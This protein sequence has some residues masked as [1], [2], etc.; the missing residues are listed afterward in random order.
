[1]KSR[2]RGLFIILA[3]CA[4]SASQAATF[5]TQLSGPAEAPPNASPGTGNATVNFDLTAHLLSIDMSFS[6]LTSG[7]TAS[8]IHCCTAPPAAAPVAT[9][10]PTFTGFPLGVTSGTYSRAFNTL[11]PATWNPTFVTANGG[12][13]AGAEAAL[14]A[15]LAAGSSYLNVHTT[16]FPAGEIRG[17]LTAAAVGQVPEPPALALFAIAVGALAVARRKRQASAR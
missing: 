17:F 7:T 11:D 14:A 10:V 1:M 2:S 15:G 4:S 12:S 8:H 6:G 3:L 13:V 16:A 5:T 9:Q